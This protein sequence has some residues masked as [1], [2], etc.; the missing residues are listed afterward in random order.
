MKT[1]TA[2]GAQIPVIGLGTWTL[3]GSACTDLVAHAL[4]LG[5]RH[6]DTAAAYDNEREVGEGIRRSGIPRED[7][8]V[9]TKVWWT[10]LAPADL[11]RSAAQ[12]LERLGLDHV[13][14]LL[15][16]WPN[17]AIPLPDTMAALNRV[18][19]KG[20]TRHIGVSNFPT[21][22][23]E[24]AVR[25]SPAPLAANQVEYHPYLNQDK[26]LAACQAN[27]LAMVAYSPLYRGGILLQQPAV[28]AAAERH[29]KT[30][31]QIVLRW[32]LQQEGLAVIP[33][34]SR[35]ERLAENIGIFDFALDSAEMEAIS[36]LRSAGRRLCDY[37]FSPEWDAP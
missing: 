31:G 13:D 33:R 22:L 7:I 5:Y 12:S 25:L 18:R 35:R 26:V 14:L 29:G 8:F 2:N 17:P 15:V 20:W 21:R 30:P 6:V 32:H 10:D 34:T 4:E 9:T 27:G 11:E 37:G 24:E 36:R 3:R 23:I 19:D 28:A 16:H 1:L